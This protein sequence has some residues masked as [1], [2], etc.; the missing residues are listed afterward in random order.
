M[1]LEVFLTRLFAL[2]ERVAHADEV[3]TFFH[4]LLRDQEDTDIHLA[5]PRTK[6]GNRASV[7]T[8]VGPHGAGRS[9]I[10]VRGHCLMCFCCLTPNP[11]PSVC[12]LPP[13]CTIAKGASTLDGMPDATRSVCCEQSCREDV[14]SA[15]QHTKTLR[16]QN[17]L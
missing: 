7:R 16:V 3:Y 6:A 17:A 10:K 1:D 5:K 11:Q 4:L 12:S 14:C 9:Q 8:S 15:Q 13:G 2:E